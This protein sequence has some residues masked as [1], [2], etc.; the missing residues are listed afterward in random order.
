MRSWLRVHRLGPAASR[1]RRRRRR[2]AISQDLV[3][4]NRLTVQPVSLEHNVTATLGKVP[5]GEADAAF[6]YRA[7]AA[8]AGDAVET[9]DIP[10]AEEYR[11]AI[12]A[13]VV[14]STTPAEG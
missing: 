10:H 4:A 6:V 13:A 11:N 14:T 3:R 1:R 5:S 8:A 12:M 2:G 7:D 9:I